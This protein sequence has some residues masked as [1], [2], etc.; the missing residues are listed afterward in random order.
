MGS[1]RYQCR[2]KFRLRPREN[3]KGVLSFIK[4]TQLNAVVKS[5]EQM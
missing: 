1:F 5:R 4:A 3:K 2:F